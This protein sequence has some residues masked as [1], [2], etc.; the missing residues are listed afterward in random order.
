MIKGEGW[1]SEF[2][3]SWRSRLGHQFIVARSGC[4]EFRRTRL[5]FPARWLPRPTVERMRSPCDDRYLGDATTTAM[6]WIRRVRVPYCVHVEHWQWYF[7]A[8]AARGYDSDS[9]LA[10]PSAPKIFYPP[11]LSTPH[12][13]ESR[14]IARIVARRSPAAK[15]NEP[16]IFFRLLYHESLSSVR[17]TKVIRGLDSLIFV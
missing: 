16:N 3:I 2:E 1:C 10:K 13:H 14:R 9:A 7:T 12:W 5:I 6:R 4:S 8:R 11:R 17:L 15:F